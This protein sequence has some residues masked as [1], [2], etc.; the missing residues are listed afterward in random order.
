MNTIYPSGSEIALN[1]DAIAD[2]E[3]LLQTRFFDTATFLKLESSQRTFETL[4]KD[5]SIIFAKHVDGTGNDYDKYPLSVLPQLEMFIIEKLPDINSYIEFMVNGKR[6][7]VLYDEWPDLSDTFAK[8]NECLTDFAFMDL[9]ASYVEN[10][11]KYGN[12]LWFLVPAKLDVDELCKIIG[13]QP[14][15]PLDSKNR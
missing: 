11:V 13:Y 4:L 12:E 1:K 9:D 14:T 2:I 6:F 15:R 3:A 10:G 7:E 5:H 8:I